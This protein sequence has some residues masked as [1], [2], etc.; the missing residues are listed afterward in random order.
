MIGRTYLER[1]KPVV[2]LIR[3]SGPGPRNVLIRREDNSLVV[4]PFRGLRRPTPTTSAPSTR[5]I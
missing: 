5:S 4:R 3:W 2:V 1:G